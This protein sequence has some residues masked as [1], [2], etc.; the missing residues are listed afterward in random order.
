MPIY[1][2]LSK[3]YENCERQSFSDFNFLMGNKK[4]KEA[5]LENPQ[6]MCVPTGK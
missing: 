6:E 3:H 1:T 5:Q 2:L 4:R